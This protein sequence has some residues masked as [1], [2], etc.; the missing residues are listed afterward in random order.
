MS[1][2]IITKEKLD[3]IGD[4]IRFELSEQDTYHIDDM[5]SKIHEIAQ[6]GGGGANIQSLSVTTNG[7]YTATG[8]VDGYSPVSVSVQP[9]LET[10]SVT[11][12]GT[13]VSTQ[14]DGY[15]TV[16]VDVAG[17]GGI[18][19]TSIDIVDALPE[20]LVEG[21]VY[22]IPN[23]EQIVPPLPLSI[24]PTMNRWAVTCEVPNEPVTFPYSLT[25][26][27]IKNSPKYYCYGHKV[28]ITAEPQS[29][30]SV[31]R[32]R[33]SYPSMINFAESNTVTMPT[34]IYKYDPSTDTDWVDITANITSTDWNN[35]VVDHDM[36]HCFY[37]TYTMIRNSL[38]H[39]SYESKWNA[40]DTNGR[41][42]KQGDVNEY[43][44][45][46]VESGVAVSKGSHTLKWVATNYI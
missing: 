9:D 20:T 41:L 11:E 42:I 39:I 7:T 35:N 45:Y 32:T 16:T 31:P 4:E 3:A 28:A 29:F 34:Y 2:V 14:H 5:P 10:L 12:N 1:K 23:G 26:A 46:L 33:S 24:D 18:E 21:A 30:V 13:Y 44:V 43:L 8:V 40:I 6:S 17:G 25:T 27:K 37:S 36:L 22:L 15:S 19:V 38:N